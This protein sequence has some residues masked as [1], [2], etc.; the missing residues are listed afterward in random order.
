MPVWDDATAEWYAAKYG[1]Y[2]TNRIGIDAVDFDGVSTVVD[3]GCG[4]GSALRHLQARFSD[5]KLL[6]VD[7]APRMLE[8]ARERSLMVTGAV[9]IQFRLGSA[10]DMPIEDGLADVVL[11]FDSFEHWH[12]HRRGLQ[13]VRRVLRPGGSLVILKD[14]GASS[15]GGSRK[16]FDGVTS[17]AGFQLVSERELA[18][19]DV[20]CTL[21]I[22]RRD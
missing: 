10:E 2:A 14:A 19:A 18:E 22:L 7:P 3:V 17:E 15:G 12:D 9:P 8:I 1:E 6:G 21:W 5:M 20:R 16:G 13:E 4:T 11:A